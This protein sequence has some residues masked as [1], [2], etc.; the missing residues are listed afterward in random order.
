MKSVEEELVKIDGS[1]RFSPQSILYAFGRRLFAVA[2]RR[3]IIYEARCGIF[4]VSTTS[5]YGFPVKVDV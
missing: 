3:L 2:P 5:V 4:L 1:L